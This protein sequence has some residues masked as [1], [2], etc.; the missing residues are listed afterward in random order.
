MFAMA[1]EIAV[2]WSVCGPLMIGFLMRQ[3]NTP[4]Q[5]WAERGFSNEEPSLVDATRRHEAPDQL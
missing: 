2:S 4:Y 3:C 5:S 1:H